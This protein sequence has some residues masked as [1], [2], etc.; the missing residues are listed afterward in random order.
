MTQAVTL[1]QLGGTDSPFFRNR[2]IN[3]DMRIDQ[4]NAGASVS[5]TD[6][7][8]YTVDRWQGVSATAGSKFT[9]QQS[10]VAPTGFSNSLLATSSSS[11][12]VG[13]TEYFFVR[14]KIEGFNTA[15]LMWGSSDAKTVTL[16]FWVRS[17]LT[18]TFGGTIVNSANSYSYPFSY[19]I[20]SANTWQQIVLTITGPTTGTWVGAT[21]GIGLQIKLS[22]GTGSTYS[23][24]AGAWVSS[25]L[26]Q[27][28]GSVSVVGTSGA[29]W[30]V[31]GVQLEIGTQATP[32]E[33][34]PYGTELSLCQR[35]F[36]SGRGAIATGHY[37]MYNISYT[38]WLGNFGSF[39]VTM[40]A[41]P[42]M[43]F[44]GGSGTNCSS[45]SVTAQSPDSFSHKTSG[46]GTGQVGSFAGATYSASSEL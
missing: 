22:L 39:P 44:T 36:W 34:R 26:V 37:L 8:Q 46:G 42:T 9:V 5:V 15:D 40:R 7:N 2:I 38:D 23:G 13:S 17:S 10:A 19:T 25:D 32:F 1:A 16:S 3:G 11:Y 18:G 29:T 4:R 20:S 24:T 27:P 6:S 35:Y 31:T 21:N 45:V 28:T 30:Y 14:Q 33:R 43:S 41:T 12:T